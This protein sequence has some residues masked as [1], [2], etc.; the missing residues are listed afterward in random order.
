VYALRRTTE[1]DFQMSLLWLEAC[2]VNRPSKTEQKTKI[3]LF[4]HTPQIQE[5][6]SIWLTNYRIKTHKKV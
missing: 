6:E 2:E 4:I 5:N 3:N 1:I